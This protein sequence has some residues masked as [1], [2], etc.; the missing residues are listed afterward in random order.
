MSKRFK[1]AFQQRGHLAGIYMTGCSANSVIG[2][3]RDT[4]QWP[5]QKGIRV[6][7]TGW[8]A[9]SRSLGA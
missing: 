5:A 1:Q 8:W 7:C 9:A 2:D 4:S 3:I 6:P